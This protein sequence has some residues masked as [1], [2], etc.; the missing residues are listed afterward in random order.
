MLIRRPGEAAI[1]LEEILPNEAENST[2]TEKAIRIEALNAL[3]PKP[4]S[5]TCCISDEMR[6]LHV[7]VFLNFNHE[8][9]KMILRKNP[10]AID[11]TDALG[12]T[13]LVISLQVRI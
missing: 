3:L 7:A 4:E 5:R 8:V 12:R 10:R 1:L 6:L 2:A 13:P 11:L 9:V